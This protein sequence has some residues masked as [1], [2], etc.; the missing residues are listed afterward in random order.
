MALNRAKIYSN[1][2]DMTCPDVRA[3]DR[4]YRRI[5]LAIRLM[6]GYH[7]AMVFQGGISSLTEEAN[8]PRNG[9]ETT[10][11]FSSAPLLSP[12]PISHSTGSEKA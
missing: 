5:F 9:G 2:A 11:I 3:N 4:K 8:E 12:Y 7:A 1:S 10:A 6:L